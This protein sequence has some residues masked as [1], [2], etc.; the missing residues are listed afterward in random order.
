MGPLEMLTP[1]SPTIFVTQFYFLHTFRLKTL[2]SWGITNTEAKI[3]Q[4]YI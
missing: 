2:L 4:S 1:S 3:L